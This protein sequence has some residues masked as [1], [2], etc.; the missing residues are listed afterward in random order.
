[1]F[2]LD[3]YAY[4]NRWIKIHPLEKFVF[5]LATMLVCLI[6]PSVVVV[7]AVLLLMTVASTKGAGTP[8][9]HFLRFMM[10]PFSF[11]LTGVLTIAFSVSHDPG[12]F[13]FGFTFGSIT[14]GASQANLMKAGFILF[15]S[16]GAVS[17]LY[18]LSL[19]TPVLEVISVLRKLKLPSLFLEL[20]GLVYRF[21]FVLMDTTALIRM[22]QSSRLGYAS[23]KNTFRS[24]SQLI[25]SLFV[26]SFHRAGELAIALTA[27]NYTGEIR[28]LEKEYPVSKRN[29]AVILG[30]ELGLLLLNFT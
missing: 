19:T 20:M 10:I 29:Y 7:W 6:S 15:K 28:T 9:W 3:T 27:R 17:C 11:I 23:A 12:G 1:M 13:L 2:D 18:F 25:S 4:T 30:I 21:I 5:A 8:V 14:V 26:R 16:L 22:S 24:L